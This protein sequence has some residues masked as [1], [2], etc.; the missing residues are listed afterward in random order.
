MGADGQVLSLR[1]L[2]QLRLISRY[3]N[4]N[5][6]SNK[7]WKLEPLRRGLEACQILHF[8]VDDS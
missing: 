6:D 4:S 8:I 5:G 1:V 2:H 3:S 7:D